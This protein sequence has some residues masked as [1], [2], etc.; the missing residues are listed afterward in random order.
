MKKISIIFLV[1]LFFIPLIVSA[2]GGRTDRYGGHRDTQ[3]VEGLGPYHFHCGGFP[4]HLHPDGVCP[5]TS[6]TTKIITPTVK[7]TTN[8]TEHKPT[9]TPIPKKQSHHVPSG[10]VRGGLLVGLG[11]LFLGTSKPKK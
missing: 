1:V 7:P 10:L 3:E 8:P 11:V 5:Y 9:A 4:A 2:H 6:R